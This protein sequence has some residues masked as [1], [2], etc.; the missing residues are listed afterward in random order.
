MRLVAITL[1]GALF[2]LNAEAAVLHVHRDHDHDH[3][4]AAHEHHLQFHD[5]SD[6][7]ELSAADE[8]MT[9]IPVVLASAAAP[10]I[11]CLATI[12][13]QAIAIDAPALS[14]VPQFAITSR[15]HA[16]PSSRPSAL[17]APPSSLLL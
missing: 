4:P 10:A 8:D 5:A 15:A 7:A 6:R 17:R 3:G 13:S 11:H 1:C 16:P 14:H 12:S 2:V 9:A